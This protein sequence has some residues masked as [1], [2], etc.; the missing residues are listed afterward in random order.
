KS[1]K[2]LLRSTTEVIDN[3][4]FITLLNESTFSNR[5]L[6]FGTHASIYLG[7]WPLTYDI[8]TNSTVDDY[9][10][11]G[12][13]FVHNNKIQHEQLQTI[14][15]EGALHKKIEQGEDVKEFIQDVITTDQEIAVNF[16]VTHHGKLEIVNKQLSD[17]VYELAIPAV[18]TTGNIRYGDVYIEVKG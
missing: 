11:A 16:S 6:S 13:V 10:E 12:K 14:Q 7:R 9:Y 18:Y 4:S 2:E 3:P 1:T 5:M 8:T 15:V 17:G